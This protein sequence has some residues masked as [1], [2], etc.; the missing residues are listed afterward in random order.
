MIRICGVAKRYSRVATQIRSG[1]DVDVILRDVSYKIS[2]SNNSGVRALFA[3]WNVG[4][5][6]KAG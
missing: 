2:Q 3:S 1:T 5:K 6:V 4:K